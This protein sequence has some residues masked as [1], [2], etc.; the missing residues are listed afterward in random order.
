MYAKRAH[1][2]ARRRHCSAE[3]MFKLFALESSRE[4]GYERRRR[5]GIRLAA[6]ARSIN[7]SHHTNSSWKSSRFRAQPFSTA[8]IVQKLSAALA[9]K[10]SLKV[11][12]HTNSAVLEQEQVN[13]VEHYAFHSRE[14]NYAARTR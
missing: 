11:L 8:I 7:E 14:V 9:S 5:A 6:A 13:F 10:N 4:Q 12:C 1:S 2:S 3:Y